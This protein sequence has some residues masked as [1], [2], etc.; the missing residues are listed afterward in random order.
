MVQLCAAGD[1]VPITACR[2]A[3]VLELLLHGLEIQV[4]RGL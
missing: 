2:K 3:L 4:L 1:V